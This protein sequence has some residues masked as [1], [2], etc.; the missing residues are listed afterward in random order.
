MWNE[1]TAPG[2]LL[3][4]GLLVRVQPGELTKGLLGV[5]DTSAVEYELF[6]DGDAEDVRVVTSGEPTPEALVAYGRAIRA[7]ES[8]RP[9][10][11]I[12]VDHRNIDLTGLST[13]AFR[14]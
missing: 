13:A 1:T 9:G 14:Q 8:F 12:L 11:R 5:C 2:W 10:L 7:H 6:W 4:G 3:T